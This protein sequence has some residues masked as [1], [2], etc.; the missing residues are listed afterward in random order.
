VAVDET[1]RSF[2][3]RRALRAGLTL[4]DAQLTLLSEVV[5][6]ALA[7]AQRIR[8]DFTRD[9]EPANAFHLPQASAAFD[10]PRL[11]PPRVQGSG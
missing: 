11:P 4:D 1:S 5:P 2:A 6:H 7:M 8:R 10:E 3:E 9:E